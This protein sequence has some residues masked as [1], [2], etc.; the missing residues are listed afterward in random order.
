MSHKKP[1]YIPEGHRKYDLL[2]FRRE[3]GGEV[4]SYPAELNAIDDLLSEYEKNGANEEGQCISLLMPYGKESYREYYNELEGYADKYRPIEPELSNALL[5]LRDT[6]KSMNVKEQWSV[7]R[8]VG[9]DRGIGFSLTPGR[10]YYWPSSFEHPEYEGVI[11]DEELTSYLY[12]C[13][14]DC[15]EILEDPTGMAEKALAGGANT[16]HE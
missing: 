5:V 16:V 6:I 12:P 10:C 1:P 13:D 7:V 4:F 14:A 2:P 11:D 3:H 9:E 8:Y 15:W